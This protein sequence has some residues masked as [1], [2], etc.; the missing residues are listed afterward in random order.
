MFDECPRYLGIHLDRSLTYKQH[1]NKTALKVRT[2]NNILSKLA[3]SRWG[4]H[5]DVLRKT[6]ISVVN[7]VADFGSQVWL[8]SNHTNLIDVQLNETMRIVTGTVRATSV[9][10]LPVLSNIV[11][12]ELRRKKS[13]DIFIFKAERH[14]NSIFF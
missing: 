13:L 4:A 6:A 8:N 5:F 1:L 7:S 9:M 11:P 2:R 3:G 12:A 10:W 14:K